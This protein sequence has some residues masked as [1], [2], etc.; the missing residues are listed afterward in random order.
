MNL[1]ME[2]TAWIQGLSLHRIMHISFTFVIE[3]LGLYKQLVSSSRTVNNSELVSPFQA[4]VVQHE[5]FYL[6]IYLFFAEVS[7][8]VLYHTQEKHRHCHN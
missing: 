3:D 7:G 1:Y 4:S 6:F 2:A 8:Q 5:T